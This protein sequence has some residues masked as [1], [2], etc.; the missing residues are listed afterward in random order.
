[1]PVTLRAIPAVAQLLA[2]PPLLDRSK[3]RRQMKRDTKTDAESSVISSCLEHRAN[4]ARD[5]SSSYSNRRDQNGLNSCCTAMWNA[6]RKTTTLSL[7]WTVCFQKQKY[8]ICE[9]LPLETK[10]SGGKLLPQ[11]DLWGEC[12]Q[13][14][15]HAGVMTRRRAKSRRNVTA[16]SYSLL[17]NI[18]VYRRK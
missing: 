1:M 3:G 18:V 10:L 16:T 4:D 11:S 7:S 2:G 9:M 8:H 17:W 6:N 12:F 15:C 5:G 14:K 13:R